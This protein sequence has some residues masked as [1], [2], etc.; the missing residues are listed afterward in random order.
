MF[1]F[2]QRQSLD[3]LRQYSSNHTAIDYPNVDG[4][5]GAIISSG[6]ATLKELKKEYTLEEACDLYEVIATTRIN[7]HLAV[8]HAQE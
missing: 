6:Q 8:K 4:F 5:I 3:F 1:F 2:R 7:E